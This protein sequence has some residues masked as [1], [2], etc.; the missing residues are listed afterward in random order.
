MTVIFTQAP[1]NGEIAGGTVTWKG[2]G[3]WTPDYICVDWN[4]GGD[5]YAYQCQLEKERDGRSNEWELEDCQKLADED[6]VKCP[7]LELGN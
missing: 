7:E 4:S 6:V 1:L 2:E 3:D 5:N